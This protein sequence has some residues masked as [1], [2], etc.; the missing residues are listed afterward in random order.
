MKKPTL[1]QMSERPTLWES[2]SV[3]DS[4]LFLVY[5]GDNCVERYYE[6][7]VNSWQKT[8]LDYKHFEFI[9]GN[10]DFLGFL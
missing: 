5:P 8:Y 3:V 1:K 6:N 10:Y 7:F 2:R 9:Q 4:E